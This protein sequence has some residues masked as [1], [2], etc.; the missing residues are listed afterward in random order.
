MKKKLLISL[1]SVAAAIALCFV[2]WNIWFFTTTVQRG[3]ALQ[4]GGEYTE[5]VDSEDGRYLFVCPE[6]AVLRAQQPTLYVYERVGEKQI[7]IW[8]DRY[9]LIETIDGKIQSALF[10]DGVAVAGAFLFNPRDPATGQKQPTQTLVL[11][12]SSG[13]NPGY[14]AECTYTL[15][16]NG[17]EITE[18]ATLHND[19]HK[20]SFI[21]ML[22][23]LGT[24]ND[25]VRAL[26]NARFYDEAGKL[27]C[28]Y[29]A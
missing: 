22:P 12:G 14:F 17:Q 20:F 3:K 10:G 7:W 1:I 2:G 23:N 18:T 4:T 27:L 28:T 25:K 16:E 29:D 9:R 24:A 13:K 11:F 21:L 26:V 6:V 19:P 15:T 5:A 8:G